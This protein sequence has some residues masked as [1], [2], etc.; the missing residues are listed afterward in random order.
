MCKNVCC[1]TSQHEDL[2]SNPHKELGVAAFVPVSPL[3]RRS[4]TERSLAGDSL[5]PVS[6]RQPVSRTYGEW[7]G[8]QQITQCSPC[9]LAP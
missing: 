7:R 6:V 5:V 9:W 8:I 4:E 1:I 2:S 3:L